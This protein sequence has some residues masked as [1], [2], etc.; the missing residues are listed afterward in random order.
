MENEFPPN[1]N[2]VRESRRPQSEVATRSEKAEVV[3]VTTSKATRRKKPLSRRFLD[4][5]AGPDNTGVFD[6]VFLDVLVPGIKDVVAEVTT[7]TV[8]RALFGESSGRRHSRGGRGGYT[9]YNRMSDPRDR[10]R[11]RGR[12]DDRRER[13]D[14]DNRGRRA[15]SSHE[16]IILDSRVEAD[17]V[18]ENLFELVSMY[19]SASMR[20]LLSLIGEPHSYTD[21]DW[22]WT[23]LR[24]ARIH[25]VRNGYLLDLPRPEALD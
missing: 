5:F 14:T 16:E 21:E 10:G 7:T 13:R 25:K 3:R 12:H 17:E 4:A 23:D 11:S 19:D 24:G 22:G 2:A 18:L 20:D 1:G 8:E 15:P 6:Y 9:S